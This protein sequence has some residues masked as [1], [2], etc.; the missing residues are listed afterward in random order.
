MTGY[1]APS[2][3]TAWS[4]RTGSR[5][6]PQVISRGRPL[7]QSVLT[8]TSTGL[9]RMNAMLDRTFRGRSWCRSGH[10]SDRTFVR[11]DADSRPNACS[12]SRVV[13]RN[14]VL[15]RVTLAVTARACRFFLERRIRVGRNTAGA[16]IERVP[17][18]AFE[19]SREPGAEQPGPRDRALAVP[20]AERV[21]GLDS[22]A[23]PRV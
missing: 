19:R 2:C 15:G 14:F 23:M 1:A 4:R 5:S 6:A 22:T 9:T 21:G 20:A 7:N 11:L 12:M 8:R 13:D 17:R 18:V 10:S 16:A 3:R